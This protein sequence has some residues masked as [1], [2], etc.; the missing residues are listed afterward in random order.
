[1]ASY[2]LPPPPSKMWAAE[3][4]LGGT[5]SDHFQLLVS[6]HWL[7]INMGYQYLVNV[8]Y[9]ASEFSLV[10]HYFLVSQLGFDVT[11]MKNTAFHSLDVPFLLLYF[12]LT[13]IIPQINCVHF[14]SCLSCF[15]SFCH[16]FLTVIVNRDILA[17]VKFLLISI[18]GTLSFL[19]KLARSSPKKLTLS[20]ELL[21]GQ[22]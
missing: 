9:Y 18:T 16:L 15:H 19:S 1:M 6:I 13:S 5:Q 10:R 11:P 7:F 2:T 14:L 17:L 21:L 3:N 8:F 20:S 12:R 4:V 22:F